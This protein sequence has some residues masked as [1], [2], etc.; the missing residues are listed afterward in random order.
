MSELK[1]GETV[2]RVDLDGG[3]L[4]AYELSRILRILKRDGRIF[5]QGVKS[6]ALPSGFLEACAEELERK[7]H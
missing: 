3:I 7:V 6:I 5:I 1:E 4:D 2:T